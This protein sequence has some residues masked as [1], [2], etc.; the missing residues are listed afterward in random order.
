MCRRVRMDTK[1]RKADTKQDRT[2]WRGREKKRYKC[3]NTKLAF[4][5][6]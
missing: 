3:I 5:V 6:Q 4:Y 1:E 2:D